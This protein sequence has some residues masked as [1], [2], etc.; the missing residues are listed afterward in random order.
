M[1]RIEFGL[2]MPYPLIPRLHIYLTFL[3]CCLSLSAASAQERKSD[4]H[5]PENI[6]QWRESDDRLGRIVTFRQE[7]TR[8][9]E[10]LEAASEQTG[11]NL[12][13]RGKRGCGGRDSIHLCSQSSA[14][15]L[16]DRTLVASQLSRRYVA[17][18]KGRGE[19]GACCLSPDKNACRPEFPPPSSGLGTTIST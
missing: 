13:Y 6:A 19:R 7:Q 15:R 8:L 9:G 12:K 10:A 2:I 11:V 14:F 5:A 1:P 16:Y 4:S 18:G 3:V 17:L